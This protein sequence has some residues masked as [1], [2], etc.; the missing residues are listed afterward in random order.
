MRYRHDVLKTAFAIP[1][2]LAACTET[3]ERSVS[4]VLTPTFNPIG[5]LGVSSNLS[6]T[7]ENSESDFVELETYTCAGTIEEHKTLFWNGKTFERTLEATG[8]LK[9][10]SD[11]NDFLVSRKIFRALPNKSE[12]IFHKSNDSEFVSIRKKTEPFGFSGF[13]YDHYKGDAYTSVGAVR[14]DSIEVTIKLRTKTEEASI[15]WE[16]LSS[17]S[18]ELGF[19]DQN[20][21]VFRCEKQ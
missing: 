1:I 6:S 10:N 9:T 4:E 21:G 19:S 8:V 20:R 13:T 18:G 3:P 14:L 5:N 11:R 2:Y 15:F 17:V 7:E 12:S 16:Q